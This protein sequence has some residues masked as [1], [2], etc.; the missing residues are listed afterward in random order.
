[1]FEGIRKLQIKAGL[2]GSRPH[3]EVKHREMSLTFGT[4]LPL[5]AFTNS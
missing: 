3:R 4:A 1:M 2:E 5:Q